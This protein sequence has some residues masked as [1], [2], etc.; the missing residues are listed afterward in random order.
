MSTYLAVIDVELQRALVDLGGQYLH[1][2]PEGGV[3]DDRLLPLLV[4]D[5]VVHLG[6]LR[7]GEDGPPPL[8]AARGLSRP[9]DLH[10]G[11]HATLEQLVGLGT[12]NAS[13]V[14][15]PVD[16]DMNTYYSED[17]PATNLSGVSAG[18]CN[19]SPTYRI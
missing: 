10:P 17:Y 13:K 12:G 5:D 15:I 19:F 3:L 9:H 8:G 7:H 14:K 4:V 18:Y 6:V 1:G 11:G 2:A 16:N